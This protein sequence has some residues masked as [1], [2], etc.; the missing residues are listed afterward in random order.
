MN[1]IGF[2]KKIRLEWLEETA[3]KYL[4]S[5]RV[6]ETAQHLD[7]YLLPEIEG[8]DSQRKHITVMKRIW[9]NVPPEHT[10]LRDQALKMIAGQPEQERIALHWGM[11][12]LAF[13][14]FLEVTTVTG[15]LFKLQEVITLGQIHHRIIDT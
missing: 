11:C 8:K 9:L 5:G 7:R 12:L 15:G 10:I 13:P 2:D 4:A 6:K 1:R 14:F 3:F